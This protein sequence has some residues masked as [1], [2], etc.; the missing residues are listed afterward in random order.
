VAVAYGYMDRSELG[1]TLLTRL[2]AARKTWAGPVAEAR[3]VARQQLAHLLETSGDPAA[4]ERI[5]REVLTVRLRDWPADSAL[6]LAA[7]HHIVEAR[8]RTLPWD[9]VQPEFQRLL[10]DEERALSAEFEV[11]L[12][13]RQIIAIH[14]GKAG[15]WSEAEGLLRRV[16][17]DAV[18]VYGENHIVALVARHNHVTALRHLERIVEADTEAHQLLG[19]LRKALGEDHV[20]TRQH[21]GVDDFLIMLV[22]SS[23]DL[24]E[25]L[26]A[27][28]LKK[29]IDMAD[30][31]DPEAA[32]EAFDALI[33][34]FGADASPG[35]A[36]IVGQG[37]F[38]KAI[39]LKRVGRPRDSVA[40]YEDLISRYDGM[41]S[42]MLREIVAM[43]FHN[44]AICVAWDPDQS[45]DAAQQASN[46]YQRLAADDPDHFS[47]T[48]AKASELVERIRSSAPAMML[49]YAS[50]AAQQGRR[51]EA[52]EVLDKLIARYGPEESPSL[53]QLVAQAMLEK[54]VV[55]GR[56]GTGNAAEPR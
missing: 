14:V 18:R 7:R 11:T 20:F 32:L 36:Q 9:Q 51:V 55:L 24:N 28:I 26:A 1:I 16:A 35:I 10:R 17:A 56:T 40:V 13:T 53:Q 42:A 15:D 2:L 44:K 33:A 43:S 22:L 4:A 5:W 3:L 29:G 6:V 30:D 19:D 41:D 39:L 27:V 50:E 52:L 37:M 23:P 45:V 38:Q 34:R 25:Q 31:E 54:A 48:A 46:R 49:E 8:S 12:A 47:E 21:F